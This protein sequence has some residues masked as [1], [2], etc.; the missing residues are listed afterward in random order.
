MRIAQRRHITPYLTVWF[1][2]WRI[3]KHLRLTII[4]PC[5]KNQLIQTNPYPRA[6]EQYR[7]ALVANASSFTAIGTGTTVANLTVVRPLL[8][9][10]HFIMPLSNQTVVRPL[11]INP[12]YLAFINEKVV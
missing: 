11:L 1:V 7:K 12:G 10:T 8:T 6:P 9:W 5:L 4:A 2:R 3:R